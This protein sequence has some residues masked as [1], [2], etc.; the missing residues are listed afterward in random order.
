MRS[1]GKG[2]ADVDVVAEAVV[3]AGVAVEVLGGVAAQTSSL[4]VVLWGGLSR[5]RCVF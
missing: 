5:H 2:A 1:R 4:L 3:V